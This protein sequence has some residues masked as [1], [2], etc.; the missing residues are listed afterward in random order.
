MEVRA[1]MRDGCSEYNFAA[2]RSG[3][4]NLN[5]LLREGVIK[6]QGFPANCPDGDVANHAQ[7][8]SFLIRTGQSTCH[9]TPFL[10]LK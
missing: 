2:A 10:R 7:W 5:F 3:A 9:G 1:A 8:M 6:V 4:V